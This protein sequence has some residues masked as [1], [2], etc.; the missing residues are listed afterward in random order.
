MLITIPQLPFSAKIYSRF[1]PFGKQ[2]TRREREYLRSKA[3]WEFFVN[4]SQMSLL[5]KLMKHSKKWVVEERGIQRL[6]AI[7]G[8]S[9]SDRLHL[10]APTLDL[11][12]LGVRS[13]L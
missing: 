11:R 9:F 2:L 7:Q 6:E 13:G 10:V 4:H 1:L 5:E 3:N 12:Q 8:S